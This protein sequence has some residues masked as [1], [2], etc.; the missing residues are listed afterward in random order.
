MDICVFFTYSLFLLVVH[1]GHLITIPKLLQKLLCNQHAW[2]T[3]KVSS[4]IKAWNSV[5]S[6]DPHQVHGP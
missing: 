6:E 3:M 1:D 5:I 2:F 4:L